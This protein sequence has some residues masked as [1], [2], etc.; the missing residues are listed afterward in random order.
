MYKNG[1]LLLISSEVHLV[2]REKDQAI[3]VALMLCYSTHWNYIR[4]TSLYWQVKRMKKG[5]I[6]IGGASTYENK[7]TE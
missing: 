7:E 3:H 6:K 2:V 4:A 1:L 5:V